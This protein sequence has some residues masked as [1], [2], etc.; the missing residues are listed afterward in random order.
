MSAETREVNQLS[1]LKRFFLRIG[2][3]IL[4]LWF[5]TLRVTWPEANK[6]KFFR[7]HGGKILLFWHNRLFVA[8][9]IYQKF[10]KQQK[11]VGLVS[12]SKD[13]AWLSAFFELVGVV[14]VRGS[15]SFRGASAL[16]ELSR[17]LIQGAL[18]AITPD[19]PRGPCY[20]VK[21]GPFALSLKAGVP[22]YFFEIQLSSFF[23]LKSWDRFRIPF[24]FSK[25][26]MEC[27]HISSREELDA[28]V[29]KE[30]P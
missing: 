2:W 19:G 13:G 11:M 4:K 20:S 22:I 7:E 27:D 21:Q 3:G 15:S 29:P 24:P 26:T 8:P 14:P 25:V 30:S 16:K 18:V 23:C 1:A 10:F 28:F 12:A 5:L 9:L 17:E 6:E